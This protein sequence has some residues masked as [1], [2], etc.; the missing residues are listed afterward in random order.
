ML[1]DEY[2]CSHGSN[3]NEKYSWS[4]GE[5]N[6]FQITTGVDETKGFHLPTVELNKQNEMFIYMTKP[7]K[8]DYK[9]DPIS[10]L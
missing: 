6:I 1:T 7:E 10:N 8:W 3:N 2:R 9:A 4:G 5:K